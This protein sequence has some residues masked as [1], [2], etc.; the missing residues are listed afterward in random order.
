MKLSLAYIK[1][2]LP[3]IEDGQLR[4]DILA[5]GLLR[6]FPS[7]EVLL[8]DKQYID[9]IP[10]VTSG[11]AK[12]VRFTDDGRS[13]FL[14][15]LRGGETCT[16]TLSSCL[17]PETSKIRAKAVAETE[18]ILLPVPRVYYYTR[19][20]PS[21]NEF[22]LDSFRTKFDAILSAFEEMAFAP[23]EHRIMH[24]LTDLATIND[25]NRL[26]ITHT[27]LAQDLGVSR[28][29]LSRVLKSLER[30]GKLELGRKAIRLTGPMPDK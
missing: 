19:H 22:A 24:Y 17:K 21:W 11:G 4:A 23:L 20:F 15:F 5:H 18:V 14:Y 7:G 30:E 12:V 13:L 1:R 25:N 26:T 8:A 28:V 2:Y 16:M 6:T 9:Y 27:D 3:T 29:G 10:L